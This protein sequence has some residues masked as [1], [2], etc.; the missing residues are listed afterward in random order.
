MLTMRPWKLLPVLAVL[1]L[2]SLLHSP[3]ALAA[4][5]LSVQLTVSPAQVTTGQTIMVTESVT[6][7]SANKQTVT[8]TN[9]LQGPA[10]ASQSQH[11]NLE[12]GQTYTQTRSY[13][14]D[15]A[16]PRGTYTLTVLATDK[17]G[18][19]TASA[20]YTISS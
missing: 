6:N 19:A 5:D 1:G 10:S 3:T 13:R 4:S 15:A 2:L 8:L 16:D 11:L 9:T 17:S 18:T 14:I 7:T 12:P 20:S